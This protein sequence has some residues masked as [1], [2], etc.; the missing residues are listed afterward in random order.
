MLNLCGVHDQ[1]DLLHLAW[2]ADSAPRHAIVLAS[3]FGV[4][5]QML[6]DL[7]EYFRR[8][9]SEDSVRSCALRVGSR[10]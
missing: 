10:T 7:F 3:A 6:E 8:L 1:H 4:R 9:T 5:Q 2:L